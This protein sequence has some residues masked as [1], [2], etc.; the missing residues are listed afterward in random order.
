MLVKKKKKTKAKGKGRGKLTFLGNITLSPGREANHDDAD[1]RVLGLD[2]NAVTS[3]GHL[4]CWVC[5]WGWG[6]VREV[7][8]TCS[9]LVELAGR[10]AAGRDLYLRRVKE[11]VRGVVVDRVRLARVLANEKERIA[12]S[13]CSDAGELDPEWICLQQY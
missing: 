11:R 10:L 7:A 2:S 4:C 1:A 5:V 3:W 6:V 9:G 13:G 8:K 12:D